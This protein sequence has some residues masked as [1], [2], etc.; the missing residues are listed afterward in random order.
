MTGG[1]VS[2]I[3]WA[4]M[5]LPGELLKYWTLIVSPLLAR[6]L[7]LTGG[8]VDAINWNEPEKRPGLV[9]SR[10]ATEMAFVWVVLCAATLIEA[11]PAAAA[12][13]TWTVTTLG[14]P[15]A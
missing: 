10:S 15:Y 13:P 14:S 1:T 5:E 8:L 12:S 7:P 4:F 11:W 3:A 9:V 6:S 2:T